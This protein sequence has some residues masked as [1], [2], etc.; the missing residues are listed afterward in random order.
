MLVAW[1][2][3]SGGNLFPLR[4]STAFK[5]TSQESLSK[6]HSV[7]LCWCQRASAPQQTSLQN[8]RSFS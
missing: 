6:C 1:A 2:R 8:I 3:G 7:G 4:R 5:Q